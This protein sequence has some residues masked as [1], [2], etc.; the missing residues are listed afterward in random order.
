MKQKLVESIPIPIPKVK[1]KWE[2]WTVVQ[3]AGD[4]L[5]LNV[6]KNKIFFARHCINVKTMDYATWR[7]G[8][9]Y[10]RNLDDAIDT[11][12]WSYGTER[13]KKRTRMSEEDENLIWSL[14]DPDGKIRKRC[15]SNT[16]YSL[17]IEKERD[18]AAELRERAE[19]NRGERVRKLMARVPKLPEDIFQ[20]IDRREDGGKNYAIKNRG[21][22]L[23]T[24]SACGNEWEL[25]KVGKKPKDQERIICPVCKA[26]IYYQAKKQKIEKKTHFCLVQPMG[27]DVSVARHFDAMIRCE[28]GSKKNVVID[29]AVRIILNKRMVAFEQRQTCWIYYNQYGMGTSFDPDPCFDNKGNKANRREYAGYLYD[30]GIEEAFRGTYYYPWANLFVQMAA[31]GVKANY[32]RMMAIDAERQATMGLMEY[33]FKGRFFRLL[34]EESENISYNGRYYGTM[35]FGDDI[36]TVFSIDDRQKINRIRDRNG[37]EIAVEW[38]RWSELYK[39]KVSDKALDW[40]EQNRI[41]PSEMQWIKC[42]F[43]P[44]QAMNYLNRQQKES[45]KG[46][47]IRTIMGQYEDYMSMCEKLH[48][49]TRDELVYRPRDLKRR[50]NEAVEETE[51]LAAEIKAEEYSKKFGAAETVLAEIK[52]KFEYSGQ[53]YFIKVPSRIADIVR[54]GN[55]LH[56][57]AGLTDRYFDRIKQHETYICFLRKIAEPDTPFYTIEVE[58]GGTIRQHRGMLDEEPDL[59]KIKPFLR[60]WQ[61]EIRKRMRKEDHD[62]EA[63][64]KEKREMNLEEL[65]KA[66]NT[67]V[68]QGLMEDFMEAVG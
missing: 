43:S 8:Y 62:R 42:R 12:Y 20:W 13:I 49:D 45:Y 14:L 66:N 27:N 6:F 16:I 3:Q 55:Y 50:H 68:L 19:H 22:G 60:E 64:S 44:E 31:A 17:I 25:K 58:P 23:W 9:W 34:E 54:E 32:N 57:C 15:W 41:R 65:R 47:K 37:G 28:G 2:W 39:Q 61:Q 56:H 4:I 33:L 11:D 30:G 36:E 46:W 53:E 38:M 59:D 10:K 29:E 21:T 51:R 24:C 26:E 40:L 63:V 35:I 18:A 1:T 5:I 67:R 52:E 7:G 48:K